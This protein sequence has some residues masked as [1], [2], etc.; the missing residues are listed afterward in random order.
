VAEIKIDQ[1]G[2]YRVYAYV[3]D[4]TGYVSTVNS[5]VQVK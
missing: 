2:N 5:P 4:G 1:A 3:A